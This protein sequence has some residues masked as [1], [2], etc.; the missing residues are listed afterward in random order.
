[1]KRRTFSFESLES[2]ELKAADITLGTNGLLLVKGTESADHIVVSQ[3][4][5]SPNGT[6]GETI[7][8]RIEDKATGNLLLQKS[9]SSRGVNQIEIDCLGGDD[10]AENNTNK[11]SIMFGG[12]GG[13]RLVGGSSYDMLY[14]GYEFGGAD[15][16]YNTLIGNGGNDT[17]MGGSA[18]DILF[19][20]GGDDWLYGTGGDDDLRG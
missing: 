4:G 8:V 18:H 16:G 6:T 11:P 12:S 1:M 17:L 15:N 13:D 19:G 9:F 14:S 7:T 20:D 10:L 5:F 2:R 3:S